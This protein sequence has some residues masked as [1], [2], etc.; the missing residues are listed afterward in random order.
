MDKVTLKYRPKNK[1]THTHTDI[2]LNGISIGYF[3]NVKKLQSDFSI[4]SN[5]NYFL[6]LIK[7]Q[8]T[9][10]YISLYF[11]KK[12]EVIKYIEQYYTF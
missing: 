6:E 7:P 8:K 2:L 12:T 10:K 1:V 5:D 4:D 9:H 11:N 3:M